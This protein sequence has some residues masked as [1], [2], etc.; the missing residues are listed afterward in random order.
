MSTGVLV[1]VGAVDFEFDVLSAAAGR[2]L[3]VV[4]RCVD[5]A[6]LLGTAATRQ[7]A[8]ALVSSALVGLD[9]EV[10]ARLR[11]ERVAIVGVADDEASLQMTFLRGLGVDAVVTVAELVDLSEVVV[12]VMTV[13]SRGTDVG[14]GAV[15]T[16]PGDDSLI[17]GPRASPGSVIAVW[18]AT[19]A[20]GRSVTALG[21]AS[22]LAESGVS[23]LLVDADVYGGSQAQLLGVLDESSGLLA[24]ARSANRGSLDPEQLSGHAR[25]VTR[26]LSILTGLPRSDRWVELSPVLLR[27]VIDSARSLCQVVVVDC[28]FCVELD[29]EVSYDTAAPRRNGATLTALELADRIVVVG[30]ADP[31]GLGRLFRALSDLATLAPSASTW[32]VVNRARASLGWSNDDVAATMRRTSQVDVDAFLPDDPASCDRAL[33]HGQSLAECA[34]GSKLAKSLRRLADS[35]AVELGLRSV[36]P[37]GTRKRSATL[38]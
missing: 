7:A 27:R 1:A 3:H 34:P 35:L 15:F 2:D 28:A 13:G 19:G 31:V 5:V 6:D 26:T 14:A 12:D 10:L 18:G 38:P 16:D 33:V 30:A 11:D 25:A 9:T 20:P 17:A 24:A 8:V 23:T 21:L 29:E 22:S 37:G 32:V 36:A 4:R